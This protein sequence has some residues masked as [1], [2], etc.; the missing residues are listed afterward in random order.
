MPLGA[1]LLGLFNLQVQIMPLPKSLPLKQGTFAVTAF[2]RGDVVHNGDVLTTYP[3][4]PGFHAV[5]SN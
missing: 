2:D 4:R 3:T 1:A 5:F